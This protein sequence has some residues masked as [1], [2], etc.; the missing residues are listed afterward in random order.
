M[1]SSLAV[2]PLTSPNA[3]QASKT[4]IEHKSAVDTLNAFKASPSDLLA[5]CKAFKCLSSVK[6][7]AFKSIFPPNALSAK[8]SFKSSIL[9][10]VFAET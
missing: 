5:L 7:S 3:L 8:A 10:P 1:M 6:K 9:S 4:S 2:A